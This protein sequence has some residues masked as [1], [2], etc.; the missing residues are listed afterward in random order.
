MKT[1]VLSALLCI[2]MIASMLMGCNAETNNS[3]K[4]NSA[5]TENET[6]H[7]EST[8]SESA[9]EETTNL[10]ENSNTES[11]SIDQT[12]EYKFNVFAYWISDASYSDHV[13]HLVNTGA[14]GNLRFDLTY[15]I[16]EN[17]KWTK[18]DVDGNVEDI[19][20]EGDEAAAQVIID[21]IHYAYPLYKACVEGTNDNFFSTN[22]IHR[23]KAIYTLIM[24]GYSTGE[25]SATIT[26]I[27]LVHNDKKGMCIDPSNAD[28]NRMVYKY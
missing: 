15:D 24:K 19:G 28:D 8:E 6:N 27:T 22:Y 7:F 21:K 23:D 10:S 3:S 18:I 14:T 20:A 12:V 2:G 9:E 13:F 17:C 4:V 11:E 26:E 16:D 5:K 1:K 25:K